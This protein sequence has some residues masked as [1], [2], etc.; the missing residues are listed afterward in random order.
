MPAAFGAVAGVVGLSFL[1]H[2]VYMAA[3]IIT[4]RKKCV[5]RS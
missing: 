2:H 3:M 5:S 4:A 1:L